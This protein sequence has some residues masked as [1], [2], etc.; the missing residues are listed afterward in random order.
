MNLVID[1]SLLAHEP[2]SLVRLPGYLKYFP[3]FVLHF[4]IDLGIEIEN[5]RV[6]LLRLLLVS[7]QCLLRLVP[8]QGWVDHTQRLVV[9]QRSV[10]NSTLGQLGVGR[11]VER[12][13]LLR[14]NIC[15][16]VLFQTALYLLYFTL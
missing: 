7:V 12:R 13:L 9:E 1:P 6:P 15:R 3:V 5:N 10:V 11:A 14:A 16:L 4:L 2:H 8:N